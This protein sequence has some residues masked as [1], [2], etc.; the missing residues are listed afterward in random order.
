MAKLPVLFAALAIFVATAGVGAAASSADAHFGQLPALSS[1]SLAWSRPF[2]VGSFVLSDYY[3]LAAPAPVAVGKGVFVLGATQSTPGGDG[4][5]LCVS[6]FHT[7]TGNLSYRVN[8][9]VRADRLLPTQIAPLHAAR[10]AIYVVISNVSGGRGIIVAFA[11]ETGRLLWRTQF[12]PRNQTAHGE[13]ASAVTTFRGRAFAMVGALA[14]CFN[15]STGLVLWSR[16][17]P[18]ARAAGILQPAPTVVAATFPPAV[19]FP[20]CCNYLQA[21]DVERGA[22]LW[23][24]SLQPPPGGLEAIMEISNLDVSDLH[25]FVTLAGVQVAAIDA[26]S[27]AVLWKQFVPQTVGVPPVIATNTP[28]LVKLPHSGGGGRAVLVPI[29]TNS[30]G[31]GPNGLLAYD[32]RTG[33]LL[34]SFLLNRSESVMSRVVVKHSRN[35]LALVA[36][37]EP[38]ALLAVD[39]DRQTGELRVSD[40]LLL[41]TPPAAE[42]YLESSN[43]VVHE[44]H[45]YMVGPDANGKATLFAMELN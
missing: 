16:A 30:T 45:A 3:N 35:G 27:G 26:T 40:S 29:Q 9:S 28:T 7:A 25:I 11:P 23:E 44:G 4:A 33:T 37:N 21:F 2:G 34:S 12:P 17:V 1:Q 32:P 24:A 14:T 10:D 6:R 18:N 39:F 42:W 31:L 20:S 15:A 22:L 8:T 13:V 43:P 36:T 41:A 19:V 5:W 38:T